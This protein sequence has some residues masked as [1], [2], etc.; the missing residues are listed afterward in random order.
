MRWFAVTLT[1]GL[2]LSSA[3]SADNPTGD[4]GRSPRRESAAES[5]V[6]G[7]S[8]GKDEVVIYRVRPG[9][10]LSLVAAEFYGDHQRTL[11][12]VMTA[13]KLRRQRKL[14][15]GE[16]LRVPVSRE[17]TTSNGDTW[18]SLAAS[19]LGDAGRS[20]FLAEFNQLTPMDSLATGTAVMIPMR[21]THTASDRETLE[22]LSQQYFGDAKHVDL[23]R[24][25][26][27]RD[28]SPLEKGDA[29]V[30][31]NLRVRVRADKVP[32]IDAA[33]MARREQHRQANAAATAALP[34]AQLAWLRSDFAGVRA[35]LSSVADKLDFLD[36]GTA[37]AVGILL[38]KA[39]LA[40]DD[41]PSAIELFRQALSRQP[42]Q[43]S[44]YFE[45][46]KVLAAWQQA[47]GKVRRESELNR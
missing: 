30:V 1:A 17:I 36:A 6:R 16:R 32:P 19:Y 24:E 5:P 47:G 22:Q 27:Q 20:R 4:A 28:G 25:Y 35:A 41:A 45:S 14:V 7:K 39:C 15:P 44:A 40:F 42:R 33:E 29:V 8:S 23:L 37:A 31:P 46:P 13:N 34:Q 3:A 18:A 10:T 21:V 9:D 11:S 43:L 26:N 2:V 38:G 12:F